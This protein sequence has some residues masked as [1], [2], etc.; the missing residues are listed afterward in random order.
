MSIL[1][2][3]SNTIKKWVMIEDDDHSNEYYKKINEGEFIQKLD[4]RFHE[5][6]GEI[7]DRVPVFNITFGIDDYSIEI[8]DIIN[9]PTK[10]VTV[11]TEIDNK[12][13]Y[14]TDL[15]ERYATYTI[16]VRS[17]DIKRKCVKIVVK[18]FITCTTKHEFPKVK[19]TELGDLLLV[20]FLKYQFSADDIRLNDGDNSLITKVT[21]TG[22]MFFIGD[23]SEFNKVFYSHLNKEIVSNPIA[24]Y[25]ISNL[26]D[27]D[28]VRYVID[29]DKRVSFSYQNGV[30]NEYVLDESD[31]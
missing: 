24:I 6:M 26:S 18:I 29:D 20:S 3:L 22:T 5:V 30:I 11:F 13:F 2:N 9:I 7:I 17:N 21:Y 16:F 25:R 27:A 1:K 10:H 12:H 31:E 15:Q 8:I 19:F 28:I 4:K 23:Y 14:L